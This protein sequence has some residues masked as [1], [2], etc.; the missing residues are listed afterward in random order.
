MAISLGPVFQAELVGVARKPRFFVG[1]VL[2]GL[3]ILFIVT[4]TYYNLSWV[5][6]RQNETIPIHA[7]AEFGQAIFGAFASLQGAVFL[8]MTPA[9]V[10][11]AIADEKQRKTLH[12]LMASQLSSGAII[13]GKI[14]ARLLRMVVLGLI[15]LPVLALVGLFGGI[16]YQVVAL[17]YAATATTTFFLASLSILCSVYAAKPRE[18]ITQAYFFAW[19]VIPTILL[20][21]MPFWVPTAQAIGEFCRP[22]LEWVEAVSPLGLT[23]QTPFMRSPT[24]LFESVAWMMGSQVVAGAILLL[25]AAW[26]L[27]PVY[28]NMDGPNLWVRVVKRGRGKSARLRIFRRPPVGDDGMLWKELHVNRMSDTRKIGL[29]LLC[30]GLVGLVVYAAWDEVSGAMIDAYNGGYWS[31]ATHQQNLNGILRG[32]NAGGLMILLFGLASLAAAGVTSEREGDT[33]T[34]LAAGLIQAAAF[35]CIDRPGV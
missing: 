10:A 21:T 35:P 3:L 7:L 20:A 18:A 1:R 13:L 22:A 19:F 26:R 17:V 31:Y 14:G 5:Y 11:G 24:A 34:N 15:G 30:V 28:R 16:D 9:L 29:A 6:I 25:V 33:W 8:V 2:Y 4:T 27:R 32:A 12:Y 23:R